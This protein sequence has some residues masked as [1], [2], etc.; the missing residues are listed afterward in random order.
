MLTVLSLHKNLRPHSLTSMSQRTNVNNCLHLVTFPPVFPDLVQQVAS[1][2]QRLKKTVQDSVQ[3][4]HCEIQLI[5]LSQSSQPIQAAALVVILK[6]LYKA[7]RTGNTATSTL[8][9]YER[10]NIAQTH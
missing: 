7:W 5:S 4:T 9:C 2:N 3:L 8:E 1:R 10:M 6:E